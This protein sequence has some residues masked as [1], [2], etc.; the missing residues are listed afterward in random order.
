ML[1]FRDDAVDTVEELSTIYFAIDA[2]FPID[3]NCKL[4]IDFPSDQPYT[5]DLAVISGDDSIVKTEGSSSITPNSA[6]NYIEFTG[7]VDYIDESKS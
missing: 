4:R 1:V 7:C 5:T 6:S 3:S 2:R